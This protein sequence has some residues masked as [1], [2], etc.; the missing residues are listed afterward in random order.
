MILVRKT[1][2]A[3]ALAAALVLT[4]PAIMLIANGVEKAE[5]SAANA[6]STTYEDAEDA[7]AKA[8]DKWKVI[9]RVYRSTSSVEYVRDKERKSRV[10]EFKS[11]GVARTQ[12]IQEV[13]FAELLE[14]GYVFKVDDLMQGKLLKEGMVKKDAKGNYRFVPKILAITD[15]F[16]LRD[17][18]KKLPTPFTNDEITVTLSLWARCHEMRR[19]KY[20]MKIDKPVEEGE[21][22][23][24]EWAMRFD[25]ASWDSKS[26]I[27]YVQV[28]TDGNIKHMFHYLKPTHV[29]ELENQGEEKKYKWLKRDYIFYWR[30]LDEWQTEE[31]PIRR[32][33]YVRALLDSQVARQTPAKGWYVFRCNLSQN[34]RNAKHFYSRDKNGAPRLKLQQ[35]KIKKIKSFDVVAGDCRIDDVKIIVTK[36]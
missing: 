4:T 18:I 2:I 30:I 11:T 9:R 17:Y 13:W 26:F 20:S 23:E 33:T 16:K 6:I 32:G 14:Q 24:V 19:P 27:V 21:E 12:W 22:V 25:P 5:S 10:V 1:G 29:A 7:A 28:E 35:L 36:K 3:T 31:G 34:L 8:G 15:R